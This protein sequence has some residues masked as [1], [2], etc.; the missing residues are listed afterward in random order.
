MEGEIDVKIYYID[1]RMTCFDCQH[2]LT[3]DFVSSQSYVCINAL[4]RRKWKQLSPRIVPFFCPSCR[5][6]LEGML[7]ESVSGEY[8]NESGE[9]V[10]FNETKLNL[11]YLRRLYIYWLTAMF[12]LS[13]K[14]SHERAIWSPTDVP[15]IEFLQS[16]SLSQIIPLFINTFKTIEIPVDACRNWNSMLVRK[17]YFKGTVVWKDQ[18]MCHLVPHLELNDNFVVQQAKTDAMPEQGLRFF[19]LDWKCEIYVGQTVYFIAFPNPVLEDCIDCVQHIIKIINGPDGQEKTFSNNNNNNINK[20]FKEIKTKKTKETKIKTQE[21]PVNAMKQVPRHIQQSFPT[22]NVTSS[23]QMPHQKN[24]PVPYDQVQQHNTSIQ[25]HH[26]HIQHKLQQ[27]HAQIQHHAQV[28]QHH[29]N[30]ELNQQ[31]QSMYTTKARNHESTY[32]GA[33]V[34]AIKERNSRISRAN[35]SGFASPQRRR[36]TFYDVGSPSTQY[37]CEEPFIGTPTMFTP[38][39]APRTLDPV[40]LRDNFVTDFL[41]E[42][43]TS[44]QDYGVPKQH[45][46]GKTR[47]SRGYEQE[48]C[49]ANAG[50][51]DMGGDFGELMQWTDPTDDVNVVEG[52]WYEATMN[53]TPTTV[54]TI[55]TG[56]ASQEDEPAGLQS[57]VGSGGLQSPVGSGGFQSPVGSSVPEGSLHHI[58]RGMPSDIQ[59]KYSR[60]SYEGLAFQTPCPPVPEDE[61]ASV[62]EQRK[63]KPTSRKTFKSIGSN[64]GPHSP[65]TTYFD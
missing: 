28:Q 52:K 27:H 56:W 65:F 40:W 51:V 4:C 31:N 15:P 34:E 33:E 45:A 63:F 22:Q 20:T 25:T 12:A 24:I 60:T 19:A 2:A 43:K 18:G 16:M 3:C 10:P 38:P 26:A 37:I 64:R 62:D 6:N 29:A 55:A 14:L 48:F 36:S 50:F 42:S 46:Y 61:P 41:Y 11:D 39:S 57:P 30:F 49:Q 23:Y 7:G 59:K 53:N 9:L 44:T 13:G 8:I 47:D 35:M 5:K 32:A 17:R 58:P 1:G 21:S 54:D